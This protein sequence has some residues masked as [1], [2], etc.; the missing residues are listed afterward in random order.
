MNERDACHRTWSDDS[1]VLHGCALPRLHIKTDEHHVCG[2]DGCE[3][4]VDVDPIERA[5]AFSNAV[6]RLQQGSYN[7]DSK[8]LAK[9]ITE[10]DELWPYVRA[11]AQRLVDEWKAACR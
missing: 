7:R 4:K 2:H 3:R 1:G 8:E 6:Q 11:G 5:N 10:V 9:A